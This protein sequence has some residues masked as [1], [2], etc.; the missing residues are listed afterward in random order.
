MMKKL[1]NLILL[2]ALALMGTA[3]SKVP[4]GHVGVKVYLL[5]GEKGVDSEELG[6][7]RYYI[8]INEEL[9]LFPTFKQNYVWTADEREGSESNESFT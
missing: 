3:C 1:T 5:G 8:G 6:V 7:G 4:S 2:G 9:Y